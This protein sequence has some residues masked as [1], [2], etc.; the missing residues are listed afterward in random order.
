MISP[1]TS[2]EVKTL[3]DQGVTPTAGQ[4]LGGRLQSVE[5]RLMSVPLLGDAITT[6]RKR[7]SEE[8]NR[9]AYARALTG[10]GVDAKTLPVGR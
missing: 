6:G 3:M 8:L 5:D 7:A 10:T 4:I 2:K 1:Q 9:A